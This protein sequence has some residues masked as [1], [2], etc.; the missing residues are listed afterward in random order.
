MKK[1][2]LVLGILMPMTVFAD[3]I[4]TSGSCAA[5]G[6]G[7][8]CLW[9][10]NSDTH[11][12]SITGKGKMAEYGFNNSHQTATSPWYAYCDS[13]QN[14]IIENGITNIGQAA[15]YSATK[16][17]TIDI[18]DSV[19][20]IGVYAFYHT[21][22]LQYVDLPEN[23]KEI[24]H[25][26]FYDSGLTNIVIPESVERIESAAFAIDSLSEITLSDALK[27]DA[28]AFWNGGG[29]YPHNNLKIYCKGDVTV[30]KANIKKSL[31]RDNHP[32]VNTLFQIYR[33]NRRIYTI[34]EANR[35]A[36]TKN[37]VSIKYR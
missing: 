30:C 29:S 16:L 10:Y 6:E 3:E 18:P 8:T 12:L 15:F 35:V 1:L 23:L 17:E 27:P 5:A 31:A 37:R 11:T 13:I 21:T 4:P 26:A 34:D 14:V 36:G 33:N 22:N 20:S 2:V 9:E 25:A 28:S 24:K 32:Q 19:T 7:N